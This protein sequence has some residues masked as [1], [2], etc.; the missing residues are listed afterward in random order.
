MWI[1][2]IQINKIYLTNPYL[3]VI[4]NKSNHMTET[5]TLCDK[6][7]AGYDCNWIVVFCLCVQVTIYGTPISL[8]WKTTFR[9]AIERVPQWHDFCGLNVCIDVSGISV[10]Y[11][12][13]RLGGILILDILRLCQLSLAHRLLVRS[14]V[15]VWFLVLWFTTKMFTRIKG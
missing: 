1:Q 7:L 4:F 5:G 11:L 12:L 6:I 9:G 14:M 15:L 10:P 13:P 2:H 8:N 3:G